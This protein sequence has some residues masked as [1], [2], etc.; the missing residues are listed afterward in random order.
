VNEK[1]EPVHNE[2]VKTEGEIRELSDEE[3]KTAVKNYAAQ[4]R[5]QGQIQLAVTLDTSQLQFASNTI[6]L[7]LS[8]ETQREMLQN[9]KQDFLD[10]IRGVL[11]SNAVN[12]EIKISESPSQVKAYKPADIFKMMAEKN[13]SLLELKKRFDLEIDY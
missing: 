8:N 6:T 1:N 5:Q 10:S 4:K 12:L 3:V 7:T 2:P 13:P 11:K 9:L